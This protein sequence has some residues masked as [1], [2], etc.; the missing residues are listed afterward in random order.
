MQCAGSK[1][2]KCRPCNRRR[3]KWRYMYLRSGI[4]TSCILPQLSPQDSG[5]DSRL[6]CCM[7]LHRQRRNLTYFSP[8]TVRCSNPLRNMGCTCIRPCHL[9]HRRT[10]HSRRIQ[11][12][13]CGCS[14][15]RHL[16]QWMDTETGIS[17]QTIR[18]DRY[19]SRFPL[20]PLA[21]FQSSDRLR[22]HLNRP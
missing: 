4:D 2:Q 16:A 15:P 12:V 8:R 13:Y 14:P 10:L 22:S 17:I 3:E 9:P 21:S 6:T 5:T 19:T 1:Y 20:R 11:G 7:P 18:T